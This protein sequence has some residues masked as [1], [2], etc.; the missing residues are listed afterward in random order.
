MLP[1]SYISLA[2]DKENRVRFLT[3]DLIGVCVLSWVRLCDPVDCSS[4][5]SSVHGILQARILEWVAISSSRDLP[6][7]GIEP[8]SPASPLLQAGS[9]QLSHW[10]S[11][12]DLARPLQLP[13]TSRKVGATSKAR[14]SKAVWLLPASCSFSPYLWRPE[15]SCKKSKKVVGLPLWRN[16][17]EKPQGDRWVN[18]QAFGLTPPPDH[19]LSIIEPPY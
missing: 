12:V 1:V 10:G 2:G 16:H 4:P 11:P 5:S 15:K 8:M 13:S 14:S 6:N 7:P 18:E 17:M 9:L 3:L 19:N